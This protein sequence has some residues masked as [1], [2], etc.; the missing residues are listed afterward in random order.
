MNF[1]KLNCVKFIKANRGAVTVATA[2]VFPVLIGFYSVAI[3]GARFNSERSRLNDAIN[4]S[5]YALAVQ[6]NPNASDAAVQSEN[7]QLVADY[8]SYYLP[9]IHPDQNNIDVIATPYVDQATGVTGID[10]Q[11]TAQEI[12]HPIFDMKRNDADSAAFNSNVTISS[13]NF[14]GK[15]RRTT[16][17]ET[18]PTDYVFVV[19]FSGSMRREVSGGYSMPGSVALVDGLK[20][21][22]LTLS[23]EVFALQDGSTVGIVPFSSGIPAILDKTN[24]A[25]ATS[26]EIGCSYIGVLKERYADINWDF[27][28][29]KPNSENFNAKLF[30]KTGFLK[31]KTVSQDVANKFLEKTNNGLRRWYLQTIAPSNGKSG[32]AAKNWLTKTTGYCKVLDKSGNVIEGNALDN[33]DW[34]TVSND[35]ILCDADPKSDINN[36]D[37]KDTFN[38][39]LSAFLEFSMLET[40]YNSFLNEYT[41]DIDSTLSGD[42]L[43]NDRNIKTFVAFQNLTQYTPLQHSCFYAF[44]AGYNVDGT[45]AMTVVSHNDNFYNYAKKIKKPS[46]YPIELTDDFNN[47]SDFSSMTPAGATE[48]LSG[49]LYA[50][51]LIAKGINTRKIIFVISDGT[52]D[53]PSFRQTLMNKKNDLCNKITKGLKIYPSGTKTDDAEIY[54][55]SLTDSQQGLDFLQEWKN[56]C[57]GQDRGYVASDLDKLKAIIGNIMFKNRIDYVNANEK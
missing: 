47:L 35:S 29:N 52:D 45:G 4:Q 10:Y 30:D 51:P 5:V 36:I 23:K 12:S 9:H 26:K 39:Q 19:D 22:V 31:N 34:S 11:V 43:F 38:K 54:Y 24:Y 21:V 7:K 49:L 13:N 18:I 44:N 15:A 25:G 53:Y 41:M 56:I 17:P 50:V 57:V 46:Y 2:I 33:I 3:D 32:K 37:N 27:W 55:I 8:L 28:Y 14:S 48:T 40:N 20:N 16:V 1:I 42:Y 6:N